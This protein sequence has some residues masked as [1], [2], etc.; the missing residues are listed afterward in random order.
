MM[1]PVESVKAVTARRLVEI[2]TEDTAAAILRFTSGALGVIEATTATRPRDLEGSLS[3]M[4]ET[5]SVVIGG[6]AVNEMV[7]WNFAERED[8]DADVFE[9][10]VIPKTVYGFGHRA[11][12]EDVLEALR[13]GRR[14]MLDGLEGRKSI[15][16]IHAIYESAA[17]GSEVRL[18]YVSRNVP[19]GR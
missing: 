6:F 7:T 9:T 12:Y 4:G 13:S 11:F 5:G 16:L 19:L 15:E 1:G 2:E 8:D 18:R 14:S 10:T 17:T 3:V